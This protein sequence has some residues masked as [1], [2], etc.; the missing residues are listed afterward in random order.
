M[1]LK[2]KYY[3]NDAQVALVKS[4]NNSV[5]GYI[6]RLLFNNF[7]YKIKVRYREGGVFKSRFQTGPETVLLTQ[8]K[9][10]FLRKR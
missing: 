9:S 3:F 5:Y 8:Q 7:G 10:A 6:L 4:S 2:F 1:R